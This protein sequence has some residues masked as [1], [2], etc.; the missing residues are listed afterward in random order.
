MIEPLRAPVRPRVRLQTSGEVTLLEEVVAEL[1]TAGE[2]RALVL[3]GE[4][5]AGTTSA[6]QHLTAQFVG[7]T[8]L[9]IEE[10]HWRIVSPHEDQ[11]W[12]VLIH[13]ENPRLTGSD[14]CRLQGWGRDE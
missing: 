6:V 3:T 4:V 14:N 5:G 1:L 10:F 13:S 7:E 8:G 2:S 9:R 12:L 11:P